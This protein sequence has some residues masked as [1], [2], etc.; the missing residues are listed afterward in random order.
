MKLNY[1]KKQASLMGRWIVTTVFCLSAIAFLWQGAFISNPSAIAAPT[2]NLI[3][4]DLGDRAQEK[5]R[6]DAGRAKNFIDETKE[7]VERTAKKNAS[8]VDR[9]TDDDSFV[10]GKAKR[11]AARIEKRAEEDAARTKKAVDKSKNAVE[12]TIDSVKDA[13]SG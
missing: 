7:K 2:N 8:K 6:E 5:N 13:F 10:E 3:A 1:L 12:R 9:A 4:A 11:D